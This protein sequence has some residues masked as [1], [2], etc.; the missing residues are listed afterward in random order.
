MSDKRF[1]DW[2]DV[3][4]N[5]CEHYWDNSCDGTDTP[6]SCNCYKANRSVVIP[7]QIKRLEK[8]VKWITWCGIITDL[9]LLLHILDHII[10]G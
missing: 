8:S 4:C 3:D 2:E 9:A 10:G 1:E 6:K 5:G 7:N